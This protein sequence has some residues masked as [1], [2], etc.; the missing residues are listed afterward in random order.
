MGEFGWAYVKGALTASGPTGSLQFRD[1]DTS[2]TQTGLSGSANL[3]F[4]TGT[5]I[6]DADGPYELRLTGT[7]TVK[8]DSF[9]SGNL[10]V[11]G[12]TT[13]IS[14]SHLIVEDPVIGLGF[15]TGSAHTGAAGDRGFVFGL[16]TD[17]NQ[18]IIWDES[19]GSFV[20][21]KVGA[22]G[23]DR[24]VYGIPEGDLT[25]LKVGGI[26]VS[27]SGEVFGYNLRTSGDLTL[28]GS[29]KTETGDISGSRGIFSK[30]FQ[31]VG[32]LKTSGSIVS[33]G[34]I[35]TEL[36]TISGSKGIFTAGLTS[37]AEILASGNIRTEL[38]T[39]SGSDAI[40]TGLVQAA[41]PVNISGATLIGH[42][43][44]PIAVSSHQVT[45]AIY[46]TS[47]QASKFSGS[48]SSSGEVFGYSLRTS[49]ILAATG[50][51]SASGG[52]SGSTAIFTGLVQAADMLHVS[53]AV[54]ILGGG[55]TT[56]PVLL[57]EADDTLTSGKVISIDHNDAATTAVTPIGIKYD[58]D[59][60]GVT[61]DTVTSNYRGIQINMADAATNHAGSTV[62][63]KG[64]DIDVDSANS[65]GTTTNIGID[66]K[67]TDAATNY[68]IKLITEDAAGS[69]DILMV[70]DSDNNDYGAISV[71]AN[72]AMQI[73]TVDAGAAAAN[74]TFN[75]DG[76]IS[77]SANHGA[78]TF[79]I[80]ASEIIA[81][82]NVTFASPAD[83]PAITLLN[84][85]GVADPNI[86]NISGS[87]KIGFGTT[88]PT[89]AWKDYEFA[90]PIHLVNSN[91][92]L[93]NDKGF[94]WGDG[95]VLIDGDGTA[96]EM[97]FKA[98]SA[99]VLT[100]KDG[101]LSSSAEI[102]GTDL[103]TSGILDTTG[104]VNAKGGFS[105]STAI[106]TGLVQGAGEV[107][108]TGNLNAASLTASVALSG[109]NL[110]LPA[111]SGSLAGGDSYLGVDNT[112]KVILATAPAGGGGGTTN[113][114]SEIIAHQIFS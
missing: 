101:S 47:S 98:N 78:N 85:S 32:D 63:M 20:I 74:L 113:D 97:I 100:L 19:S 84:V 81:S 30:D 112:G 94:R 77:A 15:G 59:K 55:V 51:V 13:T 24:V 7:L 105:G 61:A 87:N 83:G 5:T 49:G 62:I 3:I 6:D 71:S 28:T 58:F 102:F 69:T 40:F 67:V 38:G 37:S 23:P 41:G 72:G 53:G 11:L 99:T 107:H 1:D 75:V 16:R 95:S 80:Q 54:S 45:G 18:A 31:S 79:Q 17:D 111:P 12:D 76:N 70:S 106:F 68:G 110:Y 39:I 48:L 50:S 64:M 57:L 93:D 22:L 90:G 29:V 43:L 82:G 33:A 52:F 65:Q 46:L 25:T 86:I 2:A 42:G 14:A 44:S 4:I 96:E 21:G 9:L 88:A 60:D 27:G 92:F 89:Q 35:S 104:S 36:G 114:L 26:I 8:G 66:L 10:T 91:F 109:T 108:V 73:T 56:T 34:G 103:R